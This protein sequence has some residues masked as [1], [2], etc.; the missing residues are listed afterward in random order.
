MRRAGE[1][2]RSLRHLQLPPRIKG[3]SARKSRA[4]RRAGARPHGLA[5]GCVPPPRA[6]LHPRAARFADSQPRASARSWLPR[7][8]PL[9][10]GPGRT[11]GRA[12]P[13][14]ADRTCRPRPGP[15]PGAPGRP[16]RRAPLGPHPRMPGPGRRRGQ[17]E[18]GRPA[19][20][21]RESFRQASPP[22]PPGPVLRRRS[23]GWGVGG[24]RGRAPRAPPRGVFARGRRPAGDPRRNF[25][26]P[27]PAERR[28]SGECGAPGSPDTGC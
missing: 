2:G 25:L 1:R 6:R 21:R 17:Q 26:S 16:R 8:S 23:G 9:A 24:L 3:P 19:G 27:R 5:P 4:R 13:V 20:G 10:P 12:A 14:E 28:R 22:A 7:G 11:L 15:P 18:D